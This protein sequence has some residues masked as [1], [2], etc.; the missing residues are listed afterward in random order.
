MK[1]SH[2]KLTRRE[3]LKGA[4]S[5][6]A[7]SPVLR[8]LAAAQ[9]QLLQT[10]GAEPTVCEPGIIARENLHTGTLSWLLGR[11]FKSRPCRGRCAEIEGY[12][13]QTS[14]AAG[15]EIQFFVN[16]RNPRQEEFQLEIFRMG[17]Y[18]GTGARL[19]V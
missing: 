8:S 11:A 9:E 17:F 3:L 1:R 2:S 15:D 19:M 14:V 5:A 10:A 6:L 12:C 18:G 4:V 7:L 13:S 16:S